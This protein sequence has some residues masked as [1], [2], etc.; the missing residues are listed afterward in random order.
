MSKF[1]EIPKQFMES[2]AIGSERTPNIYYSGNIL[3][4]RVFWQRLY[5][6]NHLITRHTRKFGACLDFGGGGGVMLPTLAQYFKEVTLLDLD[7]TEA[8]QVTRQYRLENVLIAQEDMAT[9]NFLKSGFDSIVAADVLEHFKDPLAPIVALHGWLADDGFLFTSL[10]TENW[11]YVALRKLFGVTKPVDH[12]HTGY[13]VETCLQANGFEKVT[14]VAAPLYWHIAP[15]FLISAWRKKP[16][17]S[18]P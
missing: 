13:E 12:Y 5:L 9:C 7:A 18:H 3:M 10:P 6:L 11:V 8:R 1:I 14:S 4:R 16:Q 15:L 17:T 2:I